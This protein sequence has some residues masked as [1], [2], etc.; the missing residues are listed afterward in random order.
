[1]ARIDAPTCAGYVGDLEACECE[2]EHLLRADPT[3]A[4]LFDDLVVCGGAEPE[5]FC[6]GY[7]VAI[8]VGCEYERSDFV[9]CLEDSQGSATTCALDDPSCLM[10]C[11][12]LAAR[13]ARPR[14]Q[15]TSAPAGARSRCPRRATIGSS[16]WWPARWTH[17]VRLRRGWLPMLTGTACAGEWEALEA[18]CF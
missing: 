10:L 18:A 12:A 6:T 13:T 4:V 15:S 14:C 11:S 17:D 5:L 1:M 2:C 16:S 8:I 3:C 9:T 7:D